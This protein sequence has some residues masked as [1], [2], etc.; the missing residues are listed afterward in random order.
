MTNAPLDCYKTTYD[1]ARC[2]IGVVHL[3]YGAF[4]RAHQAIYFDDYMQMTGDLAWGIAAVNLRI[5]EAGSFAK[6]T[7]NGDGYI[8]KTTT[9]DDITNIRMVRAH[10]AFSDWSQ[11]QREAEAL[12][13]LPSVHMVTITVT[14]SG[15]YL[16]ENGQLDV[17][18]PLIATELAGGAQ[19]SIYAYL[20]QALNI[21]STEL[22]QPISVLC[23]DNIRGNGQMLEQN[24]LAYLNAANMTDL[25]TWVGANVAFPSSM[26]DRITPRAT[27]ALQSE[28]N[29]AFPGQCV[30][31]I[32][33]ESFIQ[34]AL[35]DKFAGPVPAL[36]K[37]GVEIV[38]NVHPYEEAKIRILNGGHTG[39]SY[40]GALAGHKTFDAAMR[41]PEC[42]AHFDGF[43]DNEIL[44]ALSIALPFDKAVYKQQIA[45]RFSNKAIADSLERICMD[46]YSKFPI[47]VLPTL[48]G[49]LSQGISPK[50]G[51]EA[52]A[53]WYVYARK[54]AIGQMP[55]P[56]HEPNWDALEPLLADGQEEA[57]ARSR[58][59]WGNLPE[60]NTE[61]VPDLVSTIK[62]VEQRWLI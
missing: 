43:E 25:A 28:I 59:L 60:T 18:D 41:D 61:F 40:L 54:F 55:I 49:C 9:H 39:L 57:F 27:P 11:N 29:A 6:T 62:R 13:A 52:I 12:L 44:P 38:D 36:D 56:Y 17:N 48:T 37:V 7:A 32:H 45:D 5:E 20:A 35:E 26:V 23:C 50:F 19:R 8:V 53:S 14:E 1:A 51:Y 24:F 31:P 4:H 33:A 30:D 21:R 3:G 16:D 15:Y 2:A 58:K 10:V 34:W 46:G 22:N 42:R 47:F